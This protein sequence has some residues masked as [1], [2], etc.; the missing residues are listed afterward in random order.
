MVVVLPHSCCINRF[1][2]KNKLWVWCDCFACSGTSNSTQ[3]FYQIYLSLRIVD[4]VKMFVIVSAS[5]A[6]F[7]TDQHNT[8]INSI[9]SR[10]E[11]RSKMV[12][13]QPASSRYGISAMRSGFTSS[14]WMLCYA[15]EFH[16]QTVHHHHN[17]GLR[18]RPRAAYNHFPNHSVL[19]QSFRKFSRRAHRLIAGQW[20]IWERW[21]APGPIC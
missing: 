6:L 21:A 19:F 20:P 15:A 17:N 4:L 9:R 10:L 12:R 13:V 8:S 11:H 14:I 7:E 16:C 5:F 2:R 18:P 3:R 1:G